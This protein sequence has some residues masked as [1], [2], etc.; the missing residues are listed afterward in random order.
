MFLPRDTVVAGGC[1]KGSTE[2]R[3]RC[4]PVFCWAEYLSRFSRCSYDA[5]MKK[6]AA[7]TPLAAWLACVGVFTAIDSR[8]RAQGASTP[9]EPLHFHHVHLNS[10]N[11]DAGAEY[12]PKL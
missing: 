3:G 2:A 10:V 9:V 11:P 4:A 8:A 5:A 6:M 12:Y 7:V 1:V